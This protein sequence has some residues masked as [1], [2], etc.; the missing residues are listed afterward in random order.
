VFILIFLLMFAG[1]AVLLWAG[2]LFLQGYIYTEPAEQ[3]YWRAPAAA[4]GLVVFLAFW[5][6]LESSS[7]EAKKPAHFDVLFSFSPTTDISFTE[8]WAQVENSSAKVH[9]KKGRGG[10]LSQD[11][12]STGFPRGTKWAPRDV[13]NRIVTAVFIKLDDGQEVEFQPKMKE[14]KPIF[15]KEGGEVRYVEKN[16]S[17]VI[18]ERQLEAGTYTAFSAGL[19][20]GNVLLNLL[21]LGIWFA[22][23]WLLLRFQWTHAL[24]LAVVLW[25][26]MMVAIIP[27]LL[28][29]TRKA[30]EAAA[31]EAAREPKSAAS[32]PASDIGPPMAKVTV[33]APPFVGSPGRF[34][35]GKKRAL[36]RQFDC[37]RPGRLL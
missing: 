4:G 5:C 21:H 1:L 2:T 31:K 20:F 23:L 25:L 10:F 36:N 27:M 19:F 30:A 13:N 11:N 34:A 8:F 32:A 15:E 17:R 16:G 33:P 29:Q 24:G 7:W 18:T 22:C 3:L 28:E 26:V 6:F 35:A 37:P 14:G 12:S 9:F